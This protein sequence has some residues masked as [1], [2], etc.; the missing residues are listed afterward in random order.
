MKST[1]SP[2]ST[3]SEQGRF[4]LENS[5]AIVTHG[6]SINHA[7][8]SE[9]CRDNGLDLT[10]AGLTMINVTALEEEVLH[11]IHQVLVQ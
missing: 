3:L 1:T 5:T 4:I 8:A 6:T 7:S 11:F 9:L 2:P 10:G